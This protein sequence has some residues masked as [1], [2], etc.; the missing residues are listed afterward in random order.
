[1][2]DARS[3]RAEAAGGVEESWQRAAR[4]GQAADVTRTSVTFVSSAAA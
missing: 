2:T 3:L 4:F 1:M